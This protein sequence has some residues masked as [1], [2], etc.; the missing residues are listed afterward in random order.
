MKIMEKNVRLTAVE[1]TAKYVKDNG[2]LCV[3]RV[4]VEAERPANYTSLPLKVKARYAHAK[5]QN[6][7]KYFFVSEFI[8]EMKFLEEND[9]D[10]ELTA[11]EHTTLQKYIQALE[12]LSVS[13][14]SEDIEKVGKIIQKYLTDFACVD[15]RLPIVLS[16]APIKEVL[17]GTQYDGTTSITVDSNGTDVN[18]NEYT[19]FN[20]VAP[21]EDA[22][23]QYMR[24]SLVQQIAGGDATPNGKASKTESKT[25][26]GDLDDLGI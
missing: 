4:S 26:T 8:E 1:T 12:T 17:S 21:D 5:G 23:L 24:N 20:F 13:E 10:N 22:E 9:I 15:G 11:E 3:V 19:D 25:E 7:A 18:L 2:L 14:K 6:V 16:T